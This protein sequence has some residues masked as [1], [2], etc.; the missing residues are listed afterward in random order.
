MENQTNDTQPLNN[1][2]V[3]APEMPPVIPPSQLGNQMPVVA[4]AKK[5]NPLFFVVVA[6]IIVVGAIAWWYVGQM[7][8]E[9]VVQE[10]PKIN[11]EA[12]QDAL[13]GN[14]INQVDLGNMDADLQQIDADLNSL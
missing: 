3:S 7:A 5:I 12:R 2:P 13:I 10:Q 4:S 8:P 6:V 1:N 9:P 11:Q 14:E